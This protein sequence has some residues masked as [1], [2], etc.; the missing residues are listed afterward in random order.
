ML[1]IV[2]GLF[3]RFFIHLIWLLT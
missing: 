1:Y 2:V 3:T